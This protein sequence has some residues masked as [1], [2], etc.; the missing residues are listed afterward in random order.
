[1]SVEMKQIR[2][3]NPPF[4]TLHIPQLNQ[5]KGVFRDLYNEALCEDP[6]FHFFFEPECVVRISSEGARGKIERWLEKR[7]FLFSIDD[8]LKP[9]PLS[10]QVQDIKVIDTHLNPFL[11]IF[12]E[13]SVAA[14]QMDSNE[15][16]FY[17]TKVIDEL[18]RQISSSS[19]EKVEMLEYLA[20]DKKSDFAPG[21]IPRVMETTPFGQGSL[22]VQRHLQTVA[23][24]HQLVLQRIGKKALFYLGSVVHSMFNPAGYTRN[25]ES[26]YLQHLAGFYKRSSCCKAS[27]LQMQVAL[28][29]VPLPLPFQYH[30]ILSEPKRPVREVGGYHILHSNGFIK[31]ATDAGR[32]YWHKQAEM[33]HRNPDW[34]IHFSIQE[35]SIPMAWNTLS[36]LFIEKRCGFGMKVAYE[37]M[38]DHMRGR[39]ITVYLFQYHPT[40]D[41][42]G[43]FTEADEQPASFW[44]DFIRLAEDRLDQRGVKSNGL[45]VG[46]RALGVYASLRNESFTPFRKGWVVPPRGLSGLDWSFSPEGQWVYPPNEAGYNGAQH[47]DPLL[48]TTCAIL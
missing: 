41:G 42:N 18:L 1:M 10:A 29:E 26:I 11:Q 24:I 13:H 2:Q 9:A 35:E 5:E 28:K 47:K 27:S 3:N 33:E 44:E 23:K 15:H 8:S 37:P 21:E 46:D 40:Y 39:E 16:G 36:Q 20:A 7:K 12:H 22:V 17:I 14:I 34:K 31:L 30:D 38:P 4:W 25:E 43:F 6:L 45:A 48:K 19:Q 32:I